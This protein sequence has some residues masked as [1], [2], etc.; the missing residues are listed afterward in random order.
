MFEYTKSR[1]VDVVQLVSE[2]NRLQRLVIDLMMLE[3][4]LLTI[5][6]DAPILDNWMWTS[7]NTTCL[8]GEVSG[9]PLLPGSGRQIITSDIWVMA[10]ELSCARTL[11][12]WY[13]LGR[14]Y[15]SKQSS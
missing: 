10:E 14:P 7:R 6:D 1:P 8:T 3:D 15:G 5:S 13:R 4:G 12:R 11:S 2:I 9:H